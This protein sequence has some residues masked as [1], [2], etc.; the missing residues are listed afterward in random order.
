MYIIQGTI[1][2]KKSRGSGFFQTISKEGETYCFF[3][4][5]DNFSLFENCE[6]VLSK[7]N[8]TYF[9]D[10]FVSLE[11]IAPLRLKPNNFIAASWLAELAHSFSMPDKSEFN[12]IKKC[13][14]MLLDDFNGSDLESIESDYCRISGFSEKEKKEKILA[15]YFSNSFKIRKS[16]LKQLSIRGRNDQTS[17]F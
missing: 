17:N 5:T 13:R 12:F 14:E 15:D 4:K 10:D 7:K 6:V 16:L 8:N 3:S 9:L 1:T 11:E 2:Y